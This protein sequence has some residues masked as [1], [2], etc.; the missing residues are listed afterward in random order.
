MATGVM[1]LHLLLTFLEV[2]IFLNI[3]STSSLGFATKEEKANSSGA[4]LNGLHQPFAEA[5]WDLLLW[6]RCST[7]STSPSTEAALPCAPLPCAL[8]Y[9]LVPHPGSDRIGISSLQI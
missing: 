9:H 3:L 4:P 1:I 6:P 5:R 2:Q 7:F 8:L